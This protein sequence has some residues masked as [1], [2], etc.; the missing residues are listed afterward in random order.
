MVVRDVSARDDG[1]VCGE[2][3]LPLEVYTTVD[4]IVPLLLKELVAHSLEIYKFPK[5]RLK[6]N[7]REKT[8]WKRLGSE[9]L[10]NETSEIMDRTKVARRSSDQFHPLRR[11]QD[12]DAGRSAVL[13]A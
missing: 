12:T 10:L 7:K 4:G 5:W 13:I 11:A 3:A 1:E 9:H 6:E 2:N 8:R